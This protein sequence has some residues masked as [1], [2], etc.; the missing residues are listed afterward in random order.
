MKKLARKPV[1]PSRRVVISRHQF[2]FRVRPGTLRVDP[3]F[4]LGRTFRLT[5][6]SGYPVAV[7]FPDTLNVED[8]NGRPVVRFTLLDGADKDLTVRN[9]RTG[10]HEYAVAIPE[11]RIEASGHSRPDIEIVR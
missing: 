4:G 10:R 7:V 9:R 8:V 11:V 2:G 5:N 3:A 6:I 1:H